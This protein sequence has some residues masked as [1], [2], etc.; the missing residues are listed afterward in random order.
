[1]TESFILREILAEH[2]HQYKIDDDGR[3]EAS[4]GSIG[5]S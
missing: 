4:D 5:F 1:M 3:D 2:I